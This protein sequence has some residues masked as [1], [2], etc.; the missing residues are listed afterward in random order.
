M[1]T[2]NR[3]IISFCDSE[4]LPVRTIDLK[5]PKEIELDEIEEILAGAIVAFFE[6]NF[7]EIK[8]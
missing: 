8:H 7:P 6:K 5:S 3:I 2:I 4:P 1:P